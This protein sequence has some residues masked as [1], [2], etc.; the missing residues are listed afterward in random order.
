MSEMAELYKYLKNLKN[1][2]PENI[3]IYLGI[4][5]HLN[6]GLNPEV[7][8]IISPI[9]SH[10]KEPEKFYLYEAKIF[11]KMNEDPVRK[12]EQNLYTSEIIEEKYSKD[13]TVIESIQE[14]NEEL[15]KR[16][17]SLEKIDLV[18]N[19]K[20]NKKSVA[21]LIETYVAKGKNQIIFTG[22]PGTGKTYSVREYVKDKTNNET[23]YKFVQFHPSYDYSDFVEGLR[24][25]NVGDSKKP[26]FVRMDGSFKSF[27]RMIVEKNLEAAGYGLNKDTLEELYKSISNKKKNNIELDP[28]E[29]IFINGE[30]KYYFIVD[31]INRADLAKVFGELMF[32][33]EESYRGIENRFD[34]QYKNLVTYEIVKEEDEKNVKA[35]PMDFDCFKNGFFI[36]KNLVFIG[37][38][39]DIDRSVESFDFALRRRFQWEEIKANDVMEDALWN[40]YKKGTIKAGINPTFFANSIINMNNTLVE[41]G[42]KFGLTDAYHIGPAYFKKLAGNTSEEVKSS[43]DNIFNTNI[44]SIIKEYLRGRNTNEVDDLIDECR[45]ALFNFEQSK[46][47][48]ASL[49]KIIKPSETIDYVLENKI[50]WNSNNINHNDAKYVGISDVDTK[51]VIYIANIIA[52]VKADYNKREAIFGTIDNKIN[53][54]INKCYEDQKFGEK[55]LY[56]WIMDDFIKTDMKYLQGIQPNGQ[57]FELSQELKDSKNIEEL[58]EK[59]KSI[60]FDNKKTDNDSE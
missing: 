48:N 2:N 60:V 45:K 51:K 34:T 35:K 20:A 30:K 7:K 40:M 8:W 23:E 29:A 47:L 58:A 56:F 41:K 26:S 38:M 39:N 46:V 57:Y 54:V 10:A 32:G 24:P 13:V 28:R 1:S 21:Q 4:P 44:K 55:A 52:Y 11:K 50:Y 33:L 6:K 25:V 19:S 22:A 36:P 53:E 17:V 15:K 49:L 59:M 16:G 9:S 5:E 31:E 27:C 37:T 12:E 14:L 42:N 43:L 3:K 18:D